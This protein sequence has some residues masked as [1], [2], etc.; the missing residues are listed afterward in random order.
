MSEELKIVSYN[1]R[2]DYSHDGINSF[3]HR[4]GIILDTINREK[5]DVI[6]AQEAVPNHV[7]FLRKNLSDYITIYNGRNTDFNGEGLALI[8]KKDR[9]NLI[10]L[11]FFWLS[12]TPYMPGSR[13][14]IQSRC[15]RICQVAM[16]QING[17]DKVFYVYNNHL[18]HESDSARILGI[19]QVLERV[20]A[21]NE[22]MPFPLFI[23]GDF[24]ATP[25]SETIQYC[26]NYEPIAL[27]DH[28]AHIPTTFHKFGTLN[29]D[30]KIDYIFT[31]NTTAPKV[32]DVTV[33]DETING[34]YLSDHYPVAMTVEL[35]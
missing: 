28:T 33:W 12:E 23:L 8:I 21:D 22:R 9:I 20:K 17:T 24:N 19:K 3:V 27:V 31:D 7:A 2:C 14:P 13:Y 34:I 18:D 30:E 15:P 35:D 29:Y 16:L 26:Y 4:A 1:L 25:D 32:K 5:P 6:C 10:A 11:D